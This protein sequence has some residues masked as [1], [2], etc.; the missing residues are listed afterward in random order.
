[1]GLIAIR[2]VLISWLTASV[3]LP[4]HLW[5]MSRAHPHRRCA[6]TR[7]TSGSELIVR[8]RVRRSASSAFMDARVRMTPVGAERVLLGHPTRSII[9][10][11]GVWA[12]RAGLCGVQ[13]TD[14]QGRLDR[15]P[16]SGRAGR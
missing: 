14:G 15:L 10:H 4:L 12:E 11:L 3:S 13:A 2:T 7:L 16:R 8:S 6:L 1:M 5:P 9:T